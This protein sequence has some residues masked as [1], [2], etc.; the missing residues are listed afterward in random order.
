VDVAKS[1][2]LDI[3]KLGGFLG[4][5]DMSMECSGV[6]GWFRYMY[7]LA[8]WFRTCYLTKLTFY[9]GDFLVHAALTKSSKKSSMKWILI[10]TKIN[11]ILTNFS[12]KAIY[13]KDIGGNPLL[14]K[15]FLKIEEKKNTLSTSSETSRLWIQY[16]VVIGIYI[17]MP[18]R[19]CLTF[20]L[21][22]VMFTTPKAPGYLSGFMKSL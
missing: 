12:E 18:T 19:R 5:H 14:Q 4:Q 21:W 15:A 13:S 2:N 7:M 6:R 1:E 3:V 10:F 20:F 22:H 11:E 9:K 16:S 17:C 8:T